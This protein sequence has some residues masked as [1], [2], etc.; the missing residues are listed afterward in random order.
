MSNE[1]I[2]MDTAF[3]Q[4][5]VD[6][7]DQFHQKAQK[8]ELLIQQA[9]EIWITE[10]ILSEIGDA[11]SA[12]DRLGAAQFIDFCYNSENFQVVGVDKFL[13]DRALK[14]YRNRLDKTGGLTDCISFTVMQEQDLVEALTTDKHFIQAGF[15]ALLLETS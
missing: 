10:T 6:R 12:I 1:R 9:D 4:A 3:V 8:F 14:L 5:L 15:R 7:R 2:F 13:L 11:L